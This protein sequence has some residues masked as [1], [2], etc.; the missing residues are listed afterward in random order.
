V[1]KVKESQAVVVLHSG[2]AKRL[3][4]RGVG[5]L[6]QVQRALETGLVVITLGT[7]NAYVAEELLGKP[8]DKVGHCAGYIGGEL[9]VVPAGR[10]GGDLV[11]ERGRP[12]EITGEEVRE[13]LGPGDVLIKGGNVLDPQGV[14]GVMMASP[15]GGTVGRYVTLALARGVEIVVPISLTKCIH[16]SVPQLARALG[17][18]KLAHASGLRIGLFPLVGSI[19]TEREAIELLYGVTASHLASGGVGAGE[20]AVTLLL[21]GEEGKVAQAFGELARLAQEEP[22]LEFHADPG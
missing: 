6:P 5:A 21:S 19:V 7:T 17:S 1:A 22:R 10:R 12:V 13:R 11:L 20:G 3:I 8:V 15:S 4:A 16:G 9:A 14:V 18:G 2:A